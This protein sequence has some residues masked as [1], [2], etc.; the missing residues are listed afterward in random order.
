MA[1]MNA[2]AEG[3]GGPICR[4]LGCCHDTSGAWPRNTAARMASDFFGAALSRDGVAYLSWM[5]ADKP[6]SSRQA[7]P[8]SAYGIIR[9]ARMLVARQAS[10][11][12]VS[13]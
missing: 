4:G 9:L 10:H 11:Q 7:D 13:G 2:V 12:H 3:G 8:P 5:G 1:V 6:P